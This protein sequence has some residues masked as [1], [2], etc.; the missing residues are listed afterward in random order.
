MI[1]IVYPHLNKTSTPNVIGFKLIKYLS[2]LSE[3]RAYNWDSFSTIIPK[4][5]DI[6]IGH[7]SPAPFTIMRRALKQAGWH[8]KIILQPFNED[9]KQIGFLD[10]FID[11]CDVYL[12]ITGKY[13][14]ERVEKSPFSKWLPKMIHLDLAVDPNHFPF[15]KNKFNAIGSR[16]FVYIGNDYHYKNL[17]Y[18]EKIFEEVPNIEIH[19]I[20]KVKSSSKFINHGFLDFNKQENKVLLTNFDFMITVGSADANPTTILESMSWG[21]IP[22]CTPTSGYHNVPGIVNVPLN[23]LKSSVEIIKSLNEMPIDKLLSLQ[24]HGRKMLEK[25]Y[26]W[27]NFFKVVKTQIENVDTLKSDLLIDSPTKVSIKKDFRQL[28]EFFIKAVLINIRRAL[29]G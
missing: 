15:I 25:N 14:F 1:H 22:I 20:G 29:L 9:I 2:T 23:N 13:W 27:E 26:S 12:A 17:D 24:T 19:T 11:E 21:L 6:L 7:V 18:L 5:G 4:N 28:T 3:V 16:K 8:K 10:E